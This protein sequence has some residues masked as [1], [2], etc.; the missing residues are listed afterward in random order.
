MVPCTH[1]GM[2]KFF[3]LKAID[4]LGPFAPSALPHCQ[5]GVNEERNGRLEVVK[6]LTVLSYCVGGAFISSV[7]QH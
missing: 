5:K 6:L 1:P 2:K 4:G 7:L 3:C